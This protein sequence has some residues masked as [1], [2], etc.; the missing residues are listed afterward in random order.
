MNDSIIGQGSLVDYSILDKEVLVEAGCHIGFGNDLTP[1]R[2]QPKLLRNGISI[3][4]KRARIPLGTKIGRNCVI[5]C[6]VGEDD[7]HASTIQSGKTIM[8]RR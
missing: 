2:K 3:I 7:F 8:P 5:G 1:N 4:G 6:G